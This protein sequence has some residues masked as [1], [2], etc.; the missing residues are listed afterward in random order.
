LS[1]HAGACLA[2]AVALTSTATKADYF[3]D[4]AASGRCWSNCQVSLADD[5]GFSDPSLYLPAIDQLY[6]PM[7]DVMREFAPYTGISAAYQNLPAPRDQAELE[8]RATDFFASV[9]REY[10]HLLQAVDYL[11][12]KVADYDGWIADDQAYIRANGYLPGLLQPRLDALRAELTEKIIERDRWRD[13]V[14]R[15]HEAERVYSA[16]AAEARADVVTLVQAIAPPDR[17]TLTAEELAA[18]ESLETHY[19]PEAPPSFPLMPAGP[20]ADSAAD[21]DPWRP[22][23]RPLGIDL[24]LPTQQKVEVLRGL[25]PAMAQ[26]VLTFDVLLAGLK[27]RREYANSVDHERSNLESSITMLNT[28]IAALPDDIATT[29]REAREAKEGYLSSR[30]QMA[31]RAAQNLLWTHARDDIVVPK[32]KEFLVAN[33]I[34]RLAAKLDVAPLSEIV[35][36]ARSIKWLSMWYYSGIDE[37]MAV[38]EKV[39][40]LLNP[41]FSGILQSAEFN[42]LPSTA[43]GERFA[44]EVFQQLGDDGV[45]IANAAGQVSV[46]GDYQDFLSKLMGDMGPRQTPDEL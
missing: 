43:A 33:G 15:V 8:R 24:S 40:G 22:V 14:A 19:P 18:A 10:D 30:D 17:L 32:L 39:V 3:D 26:G 42:G 21:V 20:A 37:L 36:E 7:Q 16:A 38:Q 23:E 12:A 31:L 29:E 27:T 44:R 2:A 1:L 4:V 11:S 46:D 13:Q 34:D 9:H 28:H 5:P 35:E 25:V 6:Q 41:T 45:E